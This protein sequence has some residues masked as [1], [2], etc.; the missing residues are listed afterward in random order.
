MTRRRFRRPGKR[1]RIG[2]G[3]TE[4]RRAAI[5][6]AQ[7]RYEQSAKG[8]A[9]KRRYEQTAKGKASH[10]RYCTRRIWIGGNRTAGV[11]ATVEQAQAINAHVQ[12]RKR[13]FIAESKRQYGAA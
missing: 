10:R 9:A 5:R 12:R 3:V 2:S 1:T 7:R 13:E 4:D 8:K 6:A 11:A